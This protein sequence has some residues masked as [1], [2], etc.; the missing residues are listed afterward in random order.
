MERPKISIITPSFNQ[1]AFLEETILSV[2]DQ[3]Y[4]SLEYIV[5]D[6][7][8]TDNSKEILQRYDR[9]ITYWVS[10]KD[11]GQSH[12]INK[13][14][15]RASGKIVSWLCSDDVY[16]PGTLH[17]VADHFEANEKAGM[18]HGKTILF[19]NKGK[20]LV[21]GAVD[22]DLALK[23]FAVIPYPQPSSFFRK[24]ILDQTGPLD[25]SL[26]FGM[27]YDLLIRFALKAPIA[28]VDEIFSK[29]RLHDDSK[30]V[31]Q[32]SKFGAEW[33]T[34]FCRFLLSNENNF[35]IADHLKSDGIFH[36]DGKRYKIDRTFKEKELRLI[37]GYFLYYQLVIYNDL[38]EKTHS[39][40]L[41]QLIREIDPAFYREHNVKSI[42][43]KIRVLPSPVIS[44]L[45]KLVR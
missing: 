16:T 28:K 5:I 42:E 18:I 9:Q 12:A 26:H 30:T 37:T 8:S 44:F 17:K 21:K 3:G 35:G 10:E 13:G 11:N 6:G 32:Q 29:Y 14:F 43:W 25:E 41:I 2:L 4:P 23:Y 20:E 7:G 34:V 39:L 19:D 40:R 15:S 1:G 38:L 22:K 33:L 27:D 36:D 31:S 45:R 24:E